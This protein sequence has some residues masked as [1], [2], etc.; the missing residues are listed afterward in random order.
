MDE[1]TPDAPRDEPSDVAAVPSEGGF[2][3]PQVPDEATAALRAELDAARAAL[4]EAA[5]RRKREQAQFVNDTRRIERLADDRV[6]Y[7]VQSVVGDLVPV[8]DALHGAVEGL[9]DTEHER[10]VAEGLRMVEKALFDVLARHGVERIEA[11]HQPFDPSLHE[12][13]LEMEGGPA[14]ERTV[15]QVVRPGFT[16]HGRVVRPAHVVVSRPPKGDGGRR[17]G[18]AG[19]GED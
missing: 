15:L 13:V 6:R 19:D 8:I 16:L 2:I 9:K 10:R 1:S 7:A 12:A 18:A 11:L 4:A 17:E 5:D 14:K 3:P